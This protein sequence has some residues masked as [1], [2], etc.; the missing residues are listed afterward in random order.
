[1]LLKDV[2]E[3]YSARVKGNEGGDWEH[4]KERRGKQGL[5]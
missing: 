1:M 2:I 5:A 4:I 3:E